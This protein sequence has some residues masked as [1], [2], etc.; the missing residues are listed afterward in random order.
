MRRVLRKSPRC[1]T[2]YHDADGIL[3]GMDGV[4]PGTGMDGDGASVWL[5]VGGWQAGGVT[6]VDNGRRDGRATAASSAAHQTKTVRTAHAH[7]QR[8]LLSFSAAPFIAWAHCTASASGRDL[9]DSDA[10][11]AD[12]RRRG[13]ANGAGGMWASRHHR[14]RGKRW[15]VTVTIHCTP[16]LRAIVFSHA[17]CAPSCAPLS[18]PP[19]TSLFTT[20]A[21]ISAF[22][23]QSRASRVFASSLR[24]TL[25]RAGFISARATA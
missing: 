23:Q 18:S 25:A 11:V 9:L 16:H 19:S 8:S 14:W 13:R 4:A 17:R 20:A 3:A 1:A 24:K 22:C 10:M 2:N 12:V 6:M 7:S 15:K 5:C 21:F